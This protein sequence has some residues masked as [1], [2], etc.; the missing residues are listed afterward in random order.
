MFNEL[1]H[2]AIVVP[3]TDSAL[4]IW[5]DKLGLDVLGSEVVNSGTVR[6]THLNL[7][8]VA[9]QLVQPLTK[10]H[11]LQSWLA[12]NGPGLHHF[13]LRVKNVDEATR[14]AAARGIP[15]AETTPHDGFSGKRAIF[16]DRASTGQVLVELTG[17]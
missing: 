15:V 4:L 1:D 17:P 14:E 9:L 16:L 8:G 12:A 10:D 3:D 2:I 7:N 6:L 13:C 5:R 11:P